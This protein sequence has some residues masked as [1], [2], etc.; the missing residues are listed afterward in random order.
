M[1][2]LSLWQPWA[3]LLITGAKRIETRSWPWPKSLPL[4]CRIA[5]H[6][7]KHFDAA[8]D[9]LLTQEPFASALHDL[10]A[11]PFGVLLG[12]VEVVECIAVE[13]LQV[14]QHGQW[15][16][17]P[18]GDLQNDVD[19]T[20]AAFGDY[21]PE[22]YG[23]RLRDPRPLVVPVNYRGQQRLFDVDDALLTATA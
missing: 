13:D 23:W 10:T 15:E 9:A 19:P 8:Q 14:R 12:T 11:L 17:V 22:R 2:A 3:T 18:I 4:P 1:K 7:G 20:E 21:S 5:I 16:P 6:A